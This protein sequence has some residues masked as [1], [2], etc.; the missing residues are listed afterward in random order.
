LWNRTNPAQNCTA[1]ILPDNGTLVIDNVTITITGSAIFTPPCLEHAGDLITGSTISDIKPPFHASETPQAYA[2]GAATILAWMLVVMLV[3]T[4]RTFFVGGVG[5]GVGLLG[6]RGIISGAQ[7]RTSVIGIGDRPW[8]QKVAALTVAISMTIV[9][10]DTFRV[11]ERQY[12]NGFM[13]I[14]ALRQEV[15]NSTQIK[16]SRIISDI[17]LW[18]AQ[19]QTLI[20][21]FPR[22]RE[23][24]LIKWIGFGLICFDTTFTCLNSFATASFQHNETF[25][26]AIPTL[27]DTFQLALSLMY[28]C[29][30]LY[31]AFHH[32]RYAFYH[33]L[34]WNV[35]IVAFLSLLSLASPL[36]FFIIDIANKSIAGWGDYFRWVGLAAASVIVWEWVER[37]EAL[38]REEKK[39]G[40]LGREIFDEDDSDGEEFPRRRNRRSNPL[41]TG[42]SSALDM[43]G[44]DMTARLIPRPRQ[45]QYADGGGPNRTLQQNS[46]DVNQHRTAPFIAPPQTTSPISRTDTVT[47]ASTIYSIQYS[48]FNLTNPPITRTQPPHRPAST[49]IE[50]NV[51]EEP[52]EAPASPKGSD[53]SGN[54]SNGAA[55]KE[56][57][58]TTQDMESQ[59]DTHSTNWFGVSKFF[60]RRKAQPPP[61]LRQGQVIDPVQ[62]NS[63]TE[64]GS[65]TSRN[66]WD[67]RQRW[68]PERV[69]RISDLPTMN[70]P[71]P[72]RGPNQRQRPWSPDQVGR[73]RRSESIA[74]LA[75]ND[76]TGPTGTGAQDPSSS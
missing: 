4:P 72:P 40:I 38:E 12:S 6:R 31:Y 17:F 13:N 30:V 15:T 7:G 14:V 74:P 35:S 22:H 71:A 53:G 41:Q 9:T 36:I 57:A 25:R 67:I 69:V 5:G 29:W 76:T 27:S 42:Q 39:D 18:L 26:K 23:K 16:I 62:L 43:L 33:P 10:T 50:T 59:N 3:I 1:F 32:R 19:I 21:L 64:S 63:A 48:T 28:S 68:A 44:P 34:M 47:P 73:P 61:Q 24:V 11:A 37:I 46:N 58:S 51:K 75:T 8:L 49:P 56:A 55:A 66:N 20:R 54:S 70:V 60:K 2:T 65:M 45:I 52:D